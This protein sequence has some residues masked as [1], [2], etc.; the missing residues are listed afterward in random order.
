M[1]RDS[2]TFYALCESV[3]CYWCLVH[4]FSMLNCC[5][6]PTF[7]VFTQ[8]SL[9]IVS[10]PSEPVCVQQTME[11]LAELKHPFLFCAVKH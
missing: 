3:K 10:L 9:D 1:L 11:G 6:E 8:R 2:S 4:I 5:F 7:I